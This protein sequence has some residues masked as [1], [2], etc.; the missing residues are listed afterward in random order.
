MPTND[1]DRSRNRLMEVGESNVPWCLGERSEST[2]VRQSTTEKYLMA[3]TS[4]LFSRGRA[5]TPR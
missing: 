1:A 5:A 4:A 3:S 2:V